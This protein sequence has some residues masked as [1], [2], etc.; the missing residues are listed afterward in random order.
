MKIKLILIAIITVSLISCS[1]NNS[2]NDNNDNNI[3]FGDDFTLPDNENEEAESVETVKQNEVIVE[4][5]TSSEASDDSSS[6]IEQTEY[7][8]A[9]IMWLQESLKIAGFYVSMDGSL[10]D[11]TKTQLS[12]Y[13]KSVGLESDNNYTKEVKNKL[14]QLRDERIAPNLGTNMVYINKEYYL[15]SDYV[16][17]NLVEANVRKNKS[18]ELVSEV[19][20]KTE[21]MF[22]DAEKDGLLIYLASGYRSYSYQEGIFSKRVLSHGFESAQT[23]VA[24]PG[25]S[26]HQTGLAIDITSEIMGFGLSQTFDLQPEFTW[27]INNCYKYGFILRYRDGKESITNYIYEPWH[28][29]YIGDVEIAKYIMENELVLEEYFESVE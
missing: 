7:T 15:P 4:E 18:I 24:I 16:P 10:G 6:E 1:N 13:K 29:R 11:K 5:I 14:Q 25:E 27:M 9:E 22:G 26:E 19:A 17:K 2:S 8:E 3:T 21:E 23:V 20:I 28:Y 12:E